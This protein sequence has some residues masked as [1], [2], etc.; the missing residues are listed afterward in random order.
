MYIAIEGCIASGKSSTAELL[1]DSLGFA[2]VKEQTLKHPFIAEFYSDQARFALETELGFVLVHYHQLN[3]LRATDIVADFSP[4]KDLVFAQMN[5]VGRDLDIFMSLYDKL[6]ERVPRPDVAIFLDLPVRECWLRS[7]ARGRPFEAGIRLEYLEELRS[8]YFRTLQGLGK[9]V[10]VLEIQPEESLTE[11][12][13][14]VKSLI[15]EASS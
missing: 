2:L 4:A 8:H 9:E 1:A 3:Q 15:D 7:M 13:T 10:R 5:L 11:V 6:N 14:A 12:A